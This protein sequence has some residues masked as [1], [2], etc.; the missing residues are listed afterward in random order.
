MEKQ[1]PLK[2]VD[3]PPGG[4]SMT[5]VPEKNL[6]ILLIQP[7]LEDYYTTPAR[8]QPLGLAYLKAALLRSGL[9]PVVRILDARKSNR[10]RTVKVPPALAPVTDFYLEKDS[11]PWS[12]FHRYYRFGMDLSEILERVQDFHPDW[13][14]IS[15]LFS[16]YSLQ[17]LELSRMLREKTGAL[18]VAGGA[19]AS[20]DPESL[21]TGDN[22]HF[23]IG[24]EGEGS[25]VQLIDLFRKNPDPEE[26]ELARIPGLS[27]R[28][29]DGTFF[30]AMDVA[31]FDPED[32]IPD[33]EDFKPQ[34][35]P[36]G[37]MPLAFLQTSR[38]CP[39][40]CK[41]CSIEAVSGKRYRARSV[42]SVLREMEIRYA[43][44]YRSFDFE[45]DHLTLKRTRARELFNKIGEQFFDRPLRLHARNGIYYRGLDGDLLDSMKRAG[46]RELNLSP[47]SG[48][49]GLNRDMGRSSAREEFRHVVE[50]A[51]SR[52]LQVVAYLIL[53]LPGDTLEGMLETI[54]ELAELPVLLGASPFYLTPGM[55]LA[56]GRKF[57]GEELLQGRLTS[58]GT[59][60]HF[61]PVVI[62]TLFL[63]VRILNFLKSF[64]ESHYSFLKI[65]HLM[66]KRGE[67]KEARSLYRLFRG[68]GLLDSRGESRKE[69]LKHGFDPDI[70]ES[71]KIRLS[72]LQTRAG[73]RIFFQESSSSTG[74]EF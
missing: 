46:F 14:G 68:D 25:L 73:G 57:T 19:H 24:G 27:F 17:V 2:G 66:E 59:G 47:V 64:G 13:I 56:T 69:N 67:K 53:G 18:L 62:H 48:N 30:L 71:L 52:D 1:D 15:S 40:P 37:R 28:R 3:R 70:F 41:F 61:S 20:A 5:F 65:L 4:N 54:R 55:P 10:R 8:T 29:G 26:S 35:Y 36:D 32:L 12:S 60:S 58:M 72:Y 23:V 6:R 74:R 45:D 49:E 11:T 42:E 44:G 16:A 22:C 31:R 33:F 39:I 34:D 51:F 43:E 21:L 7:P 63:A 38:G 9:N 50:A